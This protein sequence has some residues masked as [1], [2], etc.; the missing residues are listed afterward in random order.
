MEALVQPEEQDRSPA[1]VVTTAPVGKSLPSDQITPAMTGLPSDK[2]VSQQPV[3]DQTQQFKN[4]EQADQI[5]PSRWDKWAAGW[6]LLSN[7][8]PIGLPGSDEVG[9]LP[10]WGIKQ[11][12]Q[13]YSDESG[14]PT[15]S[16]DKA[17]KMYPGRAEPYAAPVSEMVAQLEYNDRQRI[18]KINEW[19]NAGGETPYTDFA[20]GLVG[21]FADPLNMALGMVAGPAGKLMGL[22]G[23]TSFAGKFA[24]R[25]AENL[26]VNAA[27]SA[28]TYG[29]EKSE[30]QNPSLGDTAKQAAEGAL[31]GTIFNTAFG[32]LLERFKA[33]S[34]A[35]RERITKEVVA[36]MDRNT[37]PNLEAQSQVLEQRRMGAIQDV[38]NIRRTVPDVSNQT[39][40]HAAVDAHG[41][42]AVF[43][44]GLG[45]GTQVHSNPDR[46]NNSVSDPE[47]GKP[48]RIGETSLPEGSKTLDVDKPASSDYEGEKSF[49]K[50]LEEK[51][52]VSI[53]DAIEGSSQISVKDVIK[54]LGDMA[55]HNDVPEDILEQAQ[56]VAKEQGYSGYSF[57]DKAQDGSN[58]GRVAHMFDENLPITGEES[59]ANPD[60]TPKL[61]SDQQSQ[62]DQEQNNKQSSAYSDPETDKAVHD[63]RHGPVLNSTPDYMD[64]FSKDIE[65]QAKNELAKFAETS[66]SAKAGLDEL[67]RMTADGKQQSAMAKALAD[68]VESGLS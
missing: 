24:A 55:G 66:D 20:Q 18:Q 60:V 3:S 16:A 41:S 51:T 58:V 50:A 63:L 19:K 7:K 68:C 53:G 37:T 49:L 57:L 38:S 26:G 6:D 64:Q 1:S 10:R 32:A 52:G 59:H 62:L 23:A 45:Q 17:N 46:V 48:G 25:Y 47:G 67:K 56:Q 33:E 54:E 42:K 43:E 35:T 5:K 15:L 2:S 39:I 4:G 40:Y 13:S 65:D 30:G 8:S 44:D 9:A 12:V 36:A 34:P 31:G 28:I 29:V 14:G 11:D 22:G 61:T 27:T 21:G